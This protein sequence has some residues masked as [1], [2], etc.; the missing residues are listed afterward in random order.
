MVRSP[1]RRRCLIN[2]SAVA[3]QADVKNRYPDGSVE[4]A[5]IAIVIPSIPAGGS[6]TLT[7]QNQA[8]PNNTPLSQAQMLG[9]QYM[10]NAR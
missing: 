10:F 6:L 2:G 8:A 9:S 4:Y 1:P 7:F 3:T 5:V